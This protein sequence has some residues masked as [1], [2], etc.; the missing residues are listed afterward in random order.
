MLVLAKVGVAI[1]VG[2][3]V[4]VGLGAEVNTVLMAFLLDLLS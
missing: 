2:V 1:N 3:A 4:T